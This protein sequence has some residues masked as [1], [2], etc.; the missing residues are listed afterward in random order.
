ML[1]QKVQVY[2]KVSGL[3][4]IQHSVILWWETGKWLERSWW[5]SLGNWQCS[6][7]WSKGTKWEFIELLGYMCMYV[8]LCTYFITEKINKRI[9][10]KPWLYI[11]VCKSLKK[12]LNLTFTLK[13][14]YFVLMYY[15]SRDYLLEDRKEKNNNKQ[16]RSEREFSS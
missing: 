7:S 15:S 6:R 4:A 12:P 13:L 1:V 16:I 8:L 5:G 3:N 9:N 10:K 14:I 11:N 2:Q